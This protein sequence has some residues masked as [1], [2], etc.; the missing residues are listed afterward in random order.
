MPPRT[1][2]VEALAASVCGVELCEQGKGSNSGTRA[3]GIPTR[4]FP[5]LRRFG[6]LLSKTGLEFI[7]VGAYQT[8]GFFPIH[9]G[10]SYELNAS[11][12][13]R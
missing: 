12:F 5:G 11:S 2:D 1:R 8:D 6:S 4:P 13:A 3:R 9:F 10:E 7:L